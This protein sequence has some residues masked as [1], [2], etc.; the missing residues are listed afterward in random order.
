MGK[1]IC[2]ALPPLAF[3]AYIVQSKVAPK[4]LIVLGGVAVMSALGAA[5]AGAMIPSIRNLPDDTAAMFVVCIG[6]I[7]VFGILLVAPALSDIIL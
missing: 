7:G 4:M 2:I 1:S 6:A 3:I 5:V